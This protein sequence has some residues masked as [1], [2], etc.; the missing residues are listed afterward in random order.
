MKQQL[1]AVEAKR[2]FPEQN[3][4]VHRLERSRKHGAKVRCPRS[5]AMCR[6]YELKTEAELLQMLQ[7]V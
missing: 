1:S 3:E 7:L 6:R 5:T 4:L 2:Q